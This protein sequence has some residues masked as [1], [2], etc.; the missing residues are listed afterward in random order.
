[1]FSARRDETNPEA[2]TPMTM[3]PRP[4]RLQ[5]SAGAT[6][7]GRRSET[8]RVRFCRGVAG[9]CTWLFCFC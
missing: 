4:P 2:V 3:T 5:E 6:N 1:M 8:Q 7:L 9:V